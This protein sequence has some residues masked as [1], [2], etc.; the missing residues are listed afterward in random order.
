MVPNQEPVRVTTQHH[1]EVVVAVLVAL[2]SQLAAIMEHA[3]VK[4]NSFSRFVSILRI[5]I[6]CE[7]SD[8]NL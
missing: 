4:K 8:K 3:Q 5:R 2:L 6:Y 1:L 7:V